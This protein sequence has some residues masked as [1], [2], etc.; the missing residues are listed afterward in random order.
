[1]IGSRGTGKVYK[2]VLKNR[3]VVVVKKIY[4][5][6]RLGENSNRKAEQRQNKMGEVEV[7]A[8]GLIRHTNILKLLCC[9]SSDESNFKLLVYEFMANGSLFDH[10]HSGP[11]PQMA[12]QWPKRYQIALGVARV[13]CYMHHNFSPPIFHIL[14][15]VKSSNILHKDVNE[16]SN[17][18]SFGVVV[19][20]LESGKKATNDEKYGEEA[21]IASWICNPI[22]MGREEMEV[23]DER[24]V[25][26]TIA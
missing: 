15:D 21:N 22:R 19:L 7:N 10:L 1:M 17:V 20:E 6:T 4:N 5:M 12:L 18:Y 9:I 13:L 2:V 23:L 11:G 25:K 14:L 8:L 26:R 16:K 24:D 3:Q